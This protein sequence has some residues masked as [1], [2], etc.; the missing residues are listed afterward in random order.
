MGRPAG[1]D[2]SPAFSYLVE[3]GDQ[4]V[5]FDPGNHLGVDEFVRQVERIVPLDQVGY[6][7]CHQPV[8]SN[9]AALLAL[10]GRLRRKD[11]V[12]VTHSSAHHDWDLL[13]IELTRRYVDQTGWNLDL[14]GRV[15]RFI[16]TAFAPARGSF[17]T[18]DTATGTLFS[19]EL[20]GALE[21]GTGLIAND[22]SCLDALFLYHEHCI[23]SREAM[24]AALR[25]FD[26][27]T[28]RSIAPHCGPMIPEHLVQ[29][30]L[31]HLEDLE[32]GLALVGEADASALLQVNRLL[33]E[34]VH[35]I[36]SEQSFQ[37]LV[38][39]L[40]ARLA[41]FL[42][43]E[44]LTF[45]IQGNR[46]T[47]VRLCAAES[48]VAIP[49]QPPE[50][51]DA[52][53]TAGTRARWH[54]RHGPRSFHMRYYAQ[55]LPDRPARPTADGTGRVHY[56]WLPLFSPADGSLLGLAR[57]ELSKPISIN[58]ELDAVLARLSGPLASCVEREVINQTLKRA[59]ERYYQMVIRDPLTGLY[60]RRYF[61]IL[62][63]HLLKRHERDPAASFAIVM[64]DLDRTGEINA[65]LGPEAADQL[66]EAIAKAIR[67]YTRG[68][69][70]AVRYGGDEFLT[71]L[72]SCQLEEVLVY[73]N[74]IRE[75]IT[76]LEDRGPAPPF[77]ITACAGVAVHV[78]GESLE[79]LVRRADRALYRAKAAGKGRLMVAEI[80]VGHKG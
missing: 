73:V 59:D 36:E 66:F 28:I 50:P 63:R 46:S 31:A 78:P 11:M 77:P 70:V 47:A 53:L 48:W 14:G 2:A 65:A 3:R 8:P 27:I 23:P 37:Q 56:L 74:R 18:F 80:P 10:Q 38:Q 67:E 21:G 72:H 42:P 7:V 9:V 52:F 40:L 25:Q 16:P 5:L 15:L 54:E 71:F 57:F 39:G 34:I 75:A 49:R 68:S 1:G 13:G 76:S 30:I 44:D 51:E 24:Q 43:A 79:G 62:A 69:D 33:R 12:L 55:P 58:R 64:L 41:P 26:D 61:D 4:S 22:T 19:G 60:S 20:F 29:P 45:T 17:C 35:G 6:V 32:C